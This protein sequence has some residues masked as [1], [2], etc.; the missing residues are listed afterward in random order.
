M[1]PISFGFREGKD[2]TKTYWNHDLVD[3]S[4]REFIETELGCLLIKKLKNSGVR[5]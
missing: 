3:K 4:V 5:I 1:I 2:K